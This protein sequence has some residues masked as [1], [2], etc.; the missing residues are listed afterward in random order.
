MGKIT[1]SKNI[2]QII[3]QNNICLYVIFAPAVHL[4][5][6]ILERRQCK[7]VRATTHFIKITLYFIISSEFNAYQMR[8]ILVFFY[9]EKDRIF[10]LVTDT[11]YIFTVPKQCFLCNFGT[12]TFF[13]RFYKKDVCQKL[14]YACCDINIKHNEVTI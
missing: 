8:I 3:L 6:I 5:R 14:C 7:K 4:I 13:K 11:I 10:S 1:K 2:E 12:G 9:S